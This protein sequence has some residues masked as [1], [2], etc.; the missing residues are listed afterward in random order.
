VQKPARS[1]GAKRKARTIV[2][3]VFAF[4]ALTACGLPQPDLIGASLSNCVTHN[5]K[6]T[7]KNRNI[8][9]FV[10]FFVRFVC[11]AGK[12]KVSDGLLETE[13][14]LKLDAAIARLT[15]EAAASASETEAAGERNRPAEK[16]RA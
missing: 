11:F 7:K 9:E 12:N 1:K 15:A 13:L 16:R 5:T 14:H 6:R 4:F 8:F 10:F 2:E 3:G